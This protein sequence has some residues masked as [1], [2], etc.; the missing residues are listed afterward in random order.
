MGSLVGW[1]STVFQASSTIS[2]ISTALLPVSLLLFLFFVNKT[3]NY[4][5]GSLLLVVTFCYIGFPFVFFSGGGI[6]SGMLA[7]MLL[8]TVI[9]SILLNG[10]DLII[11]LTMYFVISVA[12]FF[13]QSADLLPVAPIATEALLYLDIAVSFVVSGILIGLVLKYQQREYE[14]ARKTAEDA[15]RSKSEFLSNMSHEMRTP[16]NAIIG[17][18]AIAKSSPDTE[19]KDDCLSKIESASVHLLGV[20]N[21]ILDMSKI[22]A[23]KLEL[24][25]VEFDFEKMLRKTADVINFRVEEKQQDFTVYIDKNIPRNMVGD[26]Q[27]LAQVITNLLSN[28]V[29]F[30]PDRGAVHL[31]ARLLKDEDG[32]CRVMIRVSDTGIGISKEQ[33]AHL[34]N[35]FRQAESS[36]S[37]K[38]GGTGLGL[39]I[40]KRI[41]EMM[42]GKIWIESEPG[43]GASFIFTVRLQSGREA[44]QRLPGAAA[45]RRNIRILAVGGSS[46]IKEYLK[47]I[48]RSLDAVFDVAADGAEV[49]AL[50][51]KNG[52]YDVCFVD[53]KLPD[54]DSL[55]LS[56]KIKA[57]GDGGF[58]VV[59][60]SA[61]EWS[62][63]EDE[64]KIAGVDAFLSKP[65][66][67]SAIEDCIAKALGIAANPAAEGA[68]ADSPEDFSERRIL[69]AEDVEI[70]REI[71]LALLEP[72]GLAIDCAENG[73]AAV[74]MFG[75]SSDIYDMIFMDVQMPEM[76][77]YTATR[78]IRALDIP[79][80]KAIP[81]IAM[82]ANVFREDIEKCL[83]AG[84]NGHIGKP[85]DFEDVLEKLREH[86]CESGARNEK[87][88]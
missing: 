14:N 17:M 54:T 9:I 67:P 71:V 51:E 78:H 43:K 84:M 28:A 88:V 49:A 41:V 3:R 64:A 15:S 12:C 80:A 62:A 29:K 19:R 72:T 37:R 30:T 81:I 32:Q 42:D 16:M 66:F 70:N 27:R 85:L 68:R 47:D 31:L 36:T 40:S 5:M 7:Y 45:D 48:E 8:G 79:K 23:N 26:D 34:F 35:S 55:A 74:K 57:Y 83:E 46:E 25:F 22:E 75:A 33:Q 44:E 73:A 4:R 53:R 76:D 20:I 52:L 87:A 86:L 11:M 1:I 18:T 2:V 13:A 82:T 21:D 24:S 10:K 58:V 50:I 6:Y 59:V 60:S 61:T 38:F 63:I 39:A 77:G 56:R 69:L 65:V